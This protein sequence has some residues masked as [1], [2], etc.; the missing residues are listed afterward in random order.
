VQAE[1]AVQVAKT[2]PQ[3]PVSRAIQATR[4]AK[5]TEQWLRERR[6]QVIEE[7]QRLS[8]EAQSDLEASLLEDM[9]HRNVHPS[10][11]KRLQS[12]GWEHQ[13]VVQDMVRYYA[14]ATHGPQWDQPTDRELLDVAARA[15]G[16]AG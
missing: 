16:L 13:I 8:P 3:S 12:S 10:I 1:Q 2:D 9:E 11:R 4:H 14:Q 7:I 15:G 5:W 6:T